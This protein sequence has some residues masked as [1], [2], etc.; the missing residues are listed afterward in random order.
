MEAA[1]RLGV[2]VSQLTRE[3]LHERLADT[4]LEQGIAENAAAFAEWDEREWDHLVGDGFG[5]EDGE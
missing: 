3:A 5:H 4:Y 2:N 1:Q